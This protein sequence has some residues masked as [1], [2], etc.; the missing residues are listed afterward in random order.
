MRKFS[1]TIS[2]DEIKPPM[3]GGKIKFAAKLAH[4]YEDHG[5]HEVEVYPSLPERWGENKKEAEQKLR[6]SVEEWISNQNK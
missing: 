6:A 5:D 4:I 1:Y 2:I 3:S